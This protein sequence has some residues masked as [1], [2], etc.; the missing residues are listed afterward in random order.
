MESDPIKTDT[1]FI[2]SKSADGSDLIQH[3]DTEEDDSHTEGKPSPPPKKS[4]TVLPSAIPPLLPAIQD[5]RRHSPSTDTDQSTSPTRS[6]KRAIDTMLDGEED[7]EC[8]VLE[9]PPLPKRQSPPSPTKSAKM[10]SSSPSSPSSPPTFMDHALYVKGDAN[11][12][13]ACTL[14][15]SYRLHEGILENGAPILDFFDQWIKDTNPNS[16]Y[17]VDA[18]FDL[19]LEDYNPTMDEQLLSR[20]PLVMNQILQ[21]KYFHPIYSKLI[22]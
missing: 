22:Y 18:L 17:V 4:S 10:S 7:K 5:E 20:I 2:T 16:V 19:L 9:K 21:R 13:Q 14:L 15:D 3:S 12:D 8:I 6:K 1:E 11:Y